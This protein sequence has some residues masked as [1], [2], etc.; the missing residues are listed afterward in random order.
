MTTRD[1]CIQSAAAPLA[2]AYVTALGLDGTSVEDAAKAAYTPTGPSRK[3]LERRI[4]A[5]RAKHAG[6][7]AA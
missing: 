2:L 3:E 7:V 5:L 4:T 6:E 1:E